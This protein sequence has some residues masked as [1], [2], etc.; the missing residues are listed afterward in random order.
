METGQKYS[1]SITDV[2][3]SG[4]G[5]GRADGMVV[6]VPGLVPGDEAE[7]EITG[8]RKNIARGKVLQIQHPS[9][10]RTEP[11]CPVFGR[12]GGCSLQNM[13]YDAQLRLK[14][15]QLKDKL[16]RI[17]GGDIPA[18]EEPAG[19]EYPWYYRNKAEYAAGMGRRA[20]GTKGPL[21]GFYDRG[22][23][24]VVETEHCMIQSPAAN[25]AAEGLRQFIRESGISIYNERTGKGLLRRMTVRTGWESGEVMVIIT[26]NGRELPEAQLLAD[27]LSEV[28]DTEEYEFRS[29]ALEYNTNKNIAAPGAKTE[30]IAGGEV[31]HDTLL[32]MNFEISPQSFY[33]VNPAQTEVLYNTVLEFAAIGPEDVVFDLYCGVGT[34][35]IF[36]ARQAKYVW[37]IESVKSAVIDANRNAVI[38]GLVNIQF[39]RGKAE[40]KILQLEEQQIRP[41]VVILDP[42]RAGCREELIEAVNRAAPSRI[43][44]VSCEPATMARDL[45]QLTA[46]GQYRIRRIKMIDQFC[47]TV[48]MECVILLVREP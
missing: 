47:H 6:F 13:A 12:C 20:D 40:E 44:Y 18:A 22:S 39:I 7:I 16:E 26:I 19:M 38:N 34:I 48:R 46:S 30:V 8:I 35:G 37:G 41:D 33:Q 21:A 5:I 28:L 4:E 2:S 43:I 15:R 42:P 24:Q 17:C 9:P 11:P 14:D 45:K 32:G 3:T 10:E 31:I 29:L 36:C 25:L 1:I 23:R 27:I